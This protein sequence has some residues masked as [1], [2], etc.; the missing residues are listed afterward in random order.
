MK[1]IYGV[2]DK[3]PSI[4]KFEI[5]KVEVVNPEKEFKLL[6]SECVNQENKI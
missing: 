2:L 1:I 5:K 4:P 6:E 3:D